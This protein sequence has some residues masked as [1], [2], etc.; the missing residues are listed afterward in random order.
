M[1]LI[2]TSMMMLVSASVA[3]P[4]RV[5]IDPLPSAPVWW[6]QLGGDASHS[7]TP[8]TIGPHL[9]SP[10]WTSTGDGSITLSFTPQAGVVGDDLHMYAVGFDQQFMHHLAAFDQ[11]TG[12]LAWATKIPFTILDSWS[13]PTIDSNN[14]T[15]IVATGFAIVALD[16]FTGDPLWSTPMNNPIVNASPCVTNDLYG[17]NRVFITDYTFG[18]GSNGSL[19]CIN[20]DPKTPS[21]PHEPGDIVWTAIL[22]GDCSGNT[23]AYHEGVVYVST[24]DDGFGG[25]GHVLAFDAT[26]TTQ[27]LPLWDTPNTEQLG[28]F[29]AV[30]YADGFVY[31]SSYNFA[32]TQRSANT[33]KID[34]LTGSV[35]WSVPTVRTDASPIILPNNHLIISGGVPT[36]PST[37]FTGSL[38]TIELIEDLGTHA[39]VLWDSFEATHDDLNDNGTW[40]QGEPF[41]SIGGWGHHPI[42][43]INNQM[44]RLLVGTMSP[45]SGFDPFSHASDL[46]TIDL[47]KHPSDLGFI[48][49][50]QP[51]LGTTPALVGNRVF[52]TSAAGISAVPLCRSST[53][54]AL[55]E[56]IR[57]LVERLAERSTL[58]PVP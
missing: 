56:R 8:R 6:I 52:S 41:M 46:H 47:S 19:I 31:A 51:D 4:V 50:T 14:D 39:T 48:I 28:F 36:S 13:T 29:S 9:S 34:A 10:V 18:T 3:Q 33:I 1:R 45:P 15:V 11:G 30:T 5:P 17:N 7:T 27:P 26:S 37:L 42:V 54:P 44:T 20:T 12:N 32:G 58:S 53:K 2:F 23:A 21:N 43:F 38:P 55:T 40:D 49:S 25:A 22:P 57:S 35:Q 16:R 24:A